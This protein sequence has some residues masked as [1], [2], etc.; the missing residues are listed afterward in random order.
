MESYSLISGSGLVMDELFS[1]QPMNIP[2]GE[3]FSFDYI[4]EPTKEEIQQLIDKIIEECDYYCQSQIRN[5]TLLNHIS[6]FKQDIL[7][8]KSLAG[9][10]YILSKFRKSV[11]PEE[12]AE[13]IEMEINSCE[14]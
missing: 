4:Y 3:L 11:L 2:S 7:I 8:S 9:I 6:R 10:K 13:N 12:L 14:K 1:V 5:S